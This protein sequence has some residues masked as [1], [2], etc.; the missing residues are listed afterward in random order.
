MAWDTIKRIWGCRKRLI[1]VSAWG[2]QGSWLQPFLALGRLISSAKLAVVSCQFLREF[3]VGPER[4]HLPPELDARK[5]LSLSSG[6]GLVIR[7]G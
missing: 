5:P 3:E 1:G 4:S 6:L 2:I 7:A